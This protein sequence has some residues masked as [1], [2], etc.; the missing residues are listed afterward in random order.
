MSEASACARRNVSS[1]GIIHAQPNASFAAV[2]ARCQRDG[3]HV[4]PYPSRRPAELIRPGR[5]GG[6]ERRAGIVEREGVSCLKMEVADGL[7]KGIEARRTVV[8][9]ERAT[10]R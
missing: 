10:C 5:V 3:R 4:E 7:G 1:R 2:L 8:A 6:G 9:G